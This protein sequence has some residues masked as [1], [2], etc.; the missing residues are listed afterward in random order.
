VLEWAEKPKNLLQFRVALADKPLISNQAGAAL[1]R[2]QSRAMAQFTDE[3]I[4]Q[5]IADHT[6]ARQDTGGRFPIPAFDMQ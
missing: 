5:Y 4:M 2:Q 3:T 6:A 1:I